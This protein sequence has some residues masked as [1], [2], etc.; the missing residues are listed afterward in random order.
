MRIFYKF[1]V[2][3]VLLSTSLFSSNI[4][5]IT[6]LKGNANITREG[7]DIPAVLGSKLNKKDTIVTKEES[8]VQIVFNDQTIITIGRNSNFS[9][10][11]Y[12]F[13]DNNVPIAKFSLL[14]GAVRTITGQIGKIAP[15]KFSINTKTAIIGIR[16]TIFSILTSEDGSTE[17]LCSF[18]E[19]TVEVNSILTTVPQGYYV[20]ISKTGKVS[21][22]KKFT[23]SELKKIRNESLILSD[24]KDKIESDNMENS[25]IDT[26]ELKDAVTF[27]TVI[28]DPV[29][30]D[31]VDPDIG[32][33]E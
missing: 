29:N 22:V 5:T 25:I 23:S 20:A 15:D 7:S 26:D 31:P 17:V 10:N 13:E 1:F 24:I 18:G 3:C 12:L 28:A 2:L 14:K 6:L 21:K 16:G 33:T 8:K 30:P 19:V 11:E 32:P 9:I 27:D 4:G